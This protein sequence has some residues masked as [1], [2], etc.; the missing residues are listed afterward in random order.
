MIWDDELKL[1]WN[2]LI[3][4]SRLLSYNITQYRISSERSKSE[5]CEYSFYK[6][7]NLI[8]ITIFITDN[9]ISS[10]KF[11]ELTDTKSNKIIY[12]DKKDIY[13]K[14]NEITKNL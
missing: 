2:E 8:R 3:F 11:V 12:E 7:D 1:I 4:M 9:L 6:N 5:F 13:N 10:V 14:I